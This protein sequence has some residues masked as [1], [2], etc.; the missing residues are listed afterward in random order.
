MEPTFPK[1]LQIATF[2]QFIFAT[3]FHSIISFMNK[4]LRLALFLFLYILQSGGLYAQLIDWAKL[5]EGDYSCREQKISTDI[6]GNVFMTGF[7]QGS[8]SFGNVTL[9]NVKEHGI[10]TAFIAKY[11]PQGTCLWAHLLDTAVTVNALSSDSQG[12]LF[13]SGSSYGKDLQL[14]RTTLAPDNPSNALLFVAKYNPQGTCLWAAKLGEGLAYYIYVS[15]SN[16]AISKAGTIAITG[17]FPGELALVNKST[18]SNN[19]TISLTTNMFTLVCSPTGEIIW[20]NQ[21]HGQGDETGKDVA[22][23][24][25]GNVYVTGSFTEGDLYEN[26]GYST[27]FGNFTLQAKKSDIFIAKFDMTGKYVWVRQGGSDQDDTVLLEEGKGIAVDGEGNSYITGLASYYSTFGSIVTGTAKTTQTKMMATFVAKYSPTGECVWAKSFKGN[28]NTGYDVILKGNSLFVTGFFY[29]YINIGEERLYASKAV[30]AT[31]KDLFLAKFFTDGTLHWATKAGG[32]TEED[33]F[34]V[35]AGLGNKVYVIGET[36]NGSFGSSSVKG[37]LI[38]LQFSDDANVITGRVYKDSNNNG[39][40]D[41]GEL[42]ASKTVVEVL[43]GPIYCITNEQGVYRAYVREG[44][45]T[46][47]VSQ[48]PLYHSTTATHTA[49]FTLMGGLEEGNDFPMKGEVAVVDGFINL[50]GG[51]RVRPGFETSYTVTYGNRGTIAQNGNI[52]LSLDANYEYLSSTPAA[53]VNGNKL[54]WSYSDLLPDEKRTISIQLKLRA[55]VSLGTQLSTSISLTAEGSNSE[56]ANNT[57]TISQLVIGSFDPNDKAVSDSLLSPAQLRSREPLV[58]TIRFQNKGTAEA[59]FVT[60]RDSLSEKL[61]IGSFQMLAASHPYT[62]K[63]NEQGVV[64]WFFDNI[65]LAAEMHDVPGSHGFIRYQIIPKQELLLDEVIE[66]K[67]YIYFDFNAPIVT[68]VSSTTIGKHTQKISFASIGDTTFG[69]APLTL[70]AQ[71]SSGLAVLLSVISGPASLEGNTLIISGM[72]MVTLKA[73]QPGNEHYQQAEEVLVSF[74]VLPAKPII[75]T[76]GMELNSSASEGNEWYK[77]GVAISG[78]K[79]QSFHAKEKG[80]YVVKVTGPCGDPQSSEIY[81]VTVAGID[82]EISA[83]VKLYPNPS[84][85]DITIELPRIIDASKIT[86]FTMGGSQLMQQ[87]ISSKSSEFT[88]STKSLEKGIYIVKVE[89]SKGMIIKKF[90]KH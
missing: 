82:T 85:T 58:Y 19:A 87:D 33:A 38:L 2:M 7:L 32:V 22:F 28:Y 12:N 51:D 46:V 18:L 83:R 26:N 48:P 57:H 39:L 8:A 74:C 24:E 79:S 75:T 4:L 11:D 29:V 84:E 72:G 45:Y 6:E 43:P 17:S 15:A 52:A 54:S 9:T 44:N 76:N 81:N 40:F 56:L 1:P 88:F 49:S 55:S 35:S 63:L 65:N 13:I 71:A 10:G 34:G 23:D 77:D 60:L 16:L 89:T 68:N 50:Y 80:E 21:S 27:T 66:N 67:A 37:P 73:T 78:A 86:L 31:P 36:E 25:T 53:T 20:A 47:R 69:Q 70:Q 61:D 62:L 41:S 3:A 64:E 59:L 30:N 5:I 42:P 90:I 14:G